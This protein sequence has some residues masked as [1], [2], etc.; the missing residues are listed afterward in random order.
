MH[1]AT[2]NAINNSFQ[3]REEFIA[4]KQHRIIVRPEK[5]STKVRLSPRGY[6]R[7]GKVKIYTRDEILAFQ[8]SRMTL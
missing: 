1:K 7:N 5:V 8:R 3:I 4:G 2:E 6:A